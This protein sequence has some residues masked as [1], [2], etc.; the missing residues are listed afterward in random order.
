M[1]DRRAM[2]RALSLL[3]RVVRSEGQL[4]PARELDEQALSLLRQT[5][6]TDY[7][8][9]ALRVAGRTAQIACDLRTARKFLEEAVSLG[10]QQGG[11]Q[12]I[13]MRF[14]ADVLCEQREL[15][16]AAELLTQSLETHRALGSDWGTRIA[17]EGF[18][19]L[20]AA[21]GEA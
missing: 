18:A 14:L 16:T 20:A 9:I 15:E 2:G 12:A 19:R 8:P 6:D 3:A 5:G 13:G 21:K 11:V 10:R 4:A 7:L 1:G 17:L